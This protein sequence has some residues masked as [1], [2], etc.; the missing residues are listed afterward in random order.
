MPEENDDDEENMRVSRLDS[1]IYRAWFNAYLNN[2]FDLKIWPK[3]T[4]L[5]KKNHDFDKEQSF[6]PKKTEFWSEIY[7]CL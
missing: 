1:T 5:T 6:Y 4:V 7:I 2:E 3:I